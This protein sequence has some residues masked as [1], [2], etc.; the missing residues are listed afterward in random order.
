VLREVIKWV[1]GG[2]KPRKEE[3]KDYGREYQAYLGVFECL[4]LHPQKGLVYENPDNRTVR[5]CVPETMFQKIFHWSHQHRTAGH[6]GMTATQKRIREKY[7]MPNLTVRVTTAIANCVECIK[8]R[9]YVNKN[10]HLYHRSLEANPFEKIYV[11]IVGPLPESEWNGVKMK[12]VVTMMDGFT[13][14]VEAILIPETSTPQ[15][16][17]VIVD[18]WISRYGIPEQIH[19]DQGAQ[20]TSELFKGTM[21]LLG[22]VKTVT[23]PYNP[24]SNKVER[25][26]RTLGDLLRSETTGPAS[27]WMKKLPLALFAYRTAVSNATGVTPFRAMFGTNSRVP[28]DLIFPLPKEIVETWPK[29]VDKLRGRLEDIY[30]EIQKVSALGVQRAMVS[31]SGKL[32]K[33][34]EV[35]VGDTVYYFSPRVVKEGGKTS[36][37]LALLWTGPYTVIEKISDSLVKIMPMGNWAKNAWEILTVVDKLKKISCPITE[38]QLRPEEQIDMDEIEETLEDY[39]EYMREH[40]PEPEESGVPI[41]APSVMTPMIDVGAPGDEPR[42]PLTEYSSEGNLSNPVDICIDQDST[43]P[44]DTFNQGDSRSGKSEERGSSEF[45]DTPRYREAGPRK[46]LVPD[47]KDSSSSE[48]TLRSNSDVSSE[49]ESQQEIEET[50][51]ES[52]SGGK[53]QS[54]TSTRIRTYGKRKTA[55]LADALIRAGARM[56]KMEAKR[57]KISAKRKAESEDSGSEGHKRKRGKEQEEEEEGMGEGINMMIEEEE[58]N[59]LEGEKE[60]EKEEDKPDKGEVSA[61]ETEE[62]EIIEVRTVIKK[63]KVH[64]PMFERELERKRDEK[65]QE[66]IYLLTGEREEI[67]QRLE[68]G[69]HTVKKVIMFKRNKDQKESIVDVKTYLQGEKEEGD[70]E[71]YKKIK[72]G[73]EKLIFDKVDQT[74][75]EEALMTVVNIS[76]DSGMTGLDQIRDVLVAGLGGE[77]S[78]SEAKKMEEEMIEIKEK[79]RKEEEERK[80]AEKE[81]NKMKTEIKRLEEEVKEWKKTARKRKEDISS[82]EKEKKR[83]EQLLCELEWWKGDA[84]KYEDDAKRL[85]LQ[86]REE[87]KQSEHLSEELMRWKKAVKKAQEELRRN[88]EEEDELLRELDQWKND[89]KKAGIE[90]TK[91]QEALQEKERETNKLKA[92]KWKLED[93]ARREGSDAHEMQAELKQI[94]FINIELSQDIVKLKSELKECK[95]AVRKESSKSTEE[96]EKMTM[97]RKEEKSETTKRGE[98]S[99]EENEDT[100]TEGNREIQRLAKRVEIL[101]KKVEDI[102]EL[103]REVKRIRGEKG[104]E[105]KEEDKRGKKMKKDNG[106]RDKEEAKGEEEEEGGRSRMRE[107]EREKKLQVVFEL[108]NPMQTPV[109]D[110]KKKLMCIRR[111]RAENVRRINNILAGNKQQAVVANQSLSRRKIALH[112][113]GGRVFEVGVSSYELQLIQKPLTDEDSVVRPGFLKRL[114]EVRGTPHLGKEEVFIPVDCEDDWVVV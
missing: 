49:Q 90:L 8:K 41:Y 36:R 25:F 110:K 27:D 108:R 99:Q 37:K 60:I 81:N 98:D 40:F 58:R 62:G 9:N 32:R 44:A 74:R 73:V 30:R 103:K 12:Y 53:S 113:N 10:Q 79:S 85:D 16:V 68:N 102:E 105:V 39:G 4:K 57:V 92:I 38:R 95:N 55:L 50:S 86:L 84:K 51:K 28:L 109:A 93:T 104:E 34:V 77:I 76:A 29:Y 82:L 97:R 88:R 69:S 13:K 107:I 59:W 101:E 91:K 48:S 42:V 72:S 46:I 106:T 89:A 96:T 33:P 15:V 5:V 1:E 64:K 54:E 70:T 26:H 94:R 56:E 61:P 47:E 7:F 66:E 20:F 14:W 112:V 35:Q 78:P 23:P 18:G 71:I 67:R 45:S 63:A 3:T 100:D 22:I 17:Q 11:D 83:E 2:Q 24:R 65:G 6:F 80:K 114:G 21:D 87:N 31:Q 52:E 111:V 19:S 43:L 75:V